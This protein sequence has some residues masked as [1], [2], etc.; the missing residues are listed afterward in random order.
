MKLITKKS[1]CRSHPRR[2]LVKSPKDAIR[3][4]L[5][6]Y[7]IKDGVIIRVYQP[8]YVSKD[9]AVLRDVNYGNDLTIH[10]SGSSSMA[11]ITN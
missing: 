8:S 7:L 10:L 4:T 3:R 1:E 11:N 6:N 2:L 9:L 5:S